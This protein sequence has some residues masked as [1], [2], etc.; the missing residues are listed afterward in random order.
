MHFKQLKMTGFKSF[1]DPT[2]VRME[3]GTT[4]IVGPNGCG[5]SNIL[6]ALRWALGEQRAK[7]LR[8]GSMQ[9][10]IFNGS[11]DRQAMGMA[12]VT[13]TFDN[14]DSALPVDFSE[15]E[16]TRRVYRSGES[17]YLINRAPC[18]LKDI[19]EL[20]MDT[21]I[22]TQGYSM[23]GQGKIDLIVSS[24]PDERR[25]VFEE[26]AGVI[27]YKTRKRL[28]LRRLDSAEQ[29]LVRLQ[30]IIAEVERQMRT[31]KRQVNA[32]IRYRELTEQLRDVEIRAAWLQWRHFTQEVARLKEK[33]A[34]AQ[35]SFEK[36]SAENTA[37]EARSEEISL[38]RLEVDRVLQARRESVHGIDNEMERLEKQ[39]ALITQQVAFGVQQVEQAEQERA[40][41]EE[42]AVAIAERIE[43][44]KAL[45]AGMDDNRSSQTESANALHDRHE[46][47][48]AAVI[49]ADARVEDL[50]RQS[51][52]RVNTHARTVSDAEALSEQIQ[53]I[54]TQL[55]SLHERE[56]REQHEREQR[57]VDLDNA[58][59]GEARARENL[60]RTERERQ[61][62]LAGH[63][64]K[65]Q[66][67]RALQ[68]LWQTKR[69]EHSRLDARLASLR[70]LRDNYEGFA[71]GVRAI[72]KEKQ[73]GEQTLQG[74]I[75]PAGDLVSAD[76]KYEQAI[77]A[78]LGG[79]INNIIV[80]NA[81]DA[82]RAVDFLKRERAGRVTFLPLDIIR[83]GRG[84]EGK[85]L[86]GKPGV[87]GPALDFVQYESHLGKAV[88]YLLHSTLLVETLEDAIQIARV[89]SRTPKMVTLDG[90]VVTSSGAVTGGR[91][92]H[93]SRGLLGRSA[94]IED[95]EMRGQGLLTELARMQEERTALDEALQTLE[96]TAKNLDET[97]TGFRN[98]VNEFGVAIARCSTELENLAESIASL[99]AQRQELTARRDLLEERRNAALAKAD[100]L[101]TDDE[102]LQRQLAEAQDA[103]AD[104]RD[105]L[106]KCAAELSDL[107]VTAAEL[108]QQQE[109]ARR[110]LQRE[111]QLHAETLAEAKRR[112]ESAAAIVAQR[113][114]LEEQVAGNLERQKALSEGIEE[115]RKKV[116][117]AENQR[118]QL[119]DEGEKIDGTL[120][121]RRDEL[122]AAQTEVHQTEIQLRHDEDQIQFYQQRIADEY[123]VSL[124]QLTE[125]EVGTDEYGDKERTK[126]V[127]ELRK[128]IQRMG[129]VNLMA[130]DEYE[131]LEQRYTFLTTQAE[132]LRQ[133]RETLLGVVAR[134]DKKIRDLF[135]DT[136]DKI[137]KSFQET[138]RQL[139]N[140]GQARVYLL[141]PDDPLES[142]I[143]IEARPPGKKPTNIS[144]LSGGE[145]AMTAV[146]LL[147]SIF[148]AKPSP[149]C[150]LDEV[151]APLDDANIGRFLTLL[152]E[153]T[154]QSQFV[155]ITH[156]KQTM[157]RAHA[158]YGV[159]QQER[160]VSTLVS[161]RFD[162]VP[163]P[164]ESA[165]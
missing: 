146:A 112:E 123:S 3:P 113:G 69:E 9:D 22:S 50:R 125:E 127:A 151:D 13:A 33:F 64:E 88:E 161:V 60:E 56:G 153:F 29:N 20:F 90:E 135:M 27:K 11:E 59:Q 44:T 79:S 129:E 152:E 42:R 28:A 102:S 89:E 41:L 101:Q 150:I 165:A 148:R 115:A 17:E 97:G 107:R 32:A 57:A 138:F 86:L 58:H 40:A 75:G 143:E 46:E 122:R 119:L 130:I 93:E 103:A 104:A 62:A 106:A 136:F 16:I 77:E 145:R 140:G 111:Q 162:E 78:A 155:I 158:L 81:D 1:A 154:A 114:E 85:N 35:D 160:G 105:N 163:E 94:E 134:S 116:V 8:G 65:A 23:V 80:E 126:L 121:A 124:P 5:K 99:G 76:A 141:D 108:T 52:E 53:G 14:S 118:Q 70:E 83:G 25:Q 71:H 37:L 61:E 120:R 12:E 147:F 36:L 149:F 43:E 45:V 21:G 47:L 18:R 7:E 15:V 51:N 63:A 157:A 38:A 6:D 73:D 48:K 132:D 142:G 110:N 74:I 19:Q 2:V 144:L 68:E 10:V 67:L 128:Q 31:L 55:Q 159:T 92:K 117:D 156:N 34:K 131:A 49:E 30:D 91:T 72:M 26:A 4:A 66:A 87:I 164:E 98:E 54:D 137:A 82:R 96:Q 133:A 84:D 100:E 95:L 24:K 39:I 109:E 139:F